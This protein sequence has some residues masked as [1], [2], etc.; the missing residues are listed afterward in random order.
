MELIF[1]SVI[2]NQ[3]VDS[4]KQELGFESL[5]KEDI[6]RR[7]E[8]NSTSLVVT[9]NL[10]R[11]KHRNEQIWNQYFADNPEGGGVVINENLLS[12]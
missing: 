12:N 9:L 2:S 8:H 11:I 10:Q 4:F 1:F 7:I 6:N 5:S 3:E